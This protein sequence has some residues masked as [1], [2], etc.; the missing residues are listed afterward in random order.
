MPAHAHVASKPTK[1][2]NYQE[3]PLDFNP[4]HTKAKTY[5]YTIIHSP[6]RPVIGREAVWHTAWTLDFDLLAR[7]AKRFEG[8]HFL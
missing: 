1:A 2:L 8:S 4:M 5:R 3:V 7:A 6:I